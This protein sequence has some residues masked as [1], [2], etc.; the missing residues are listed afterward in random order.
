MQISGNPITQEDQGISPFSQHMMKIKVMA[1]MDKEVK[2]ITKAGP[3]PIS[4]RGLNIPITNELLNH[5]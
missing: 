2:A 3:A 4:A 1:N 5:T